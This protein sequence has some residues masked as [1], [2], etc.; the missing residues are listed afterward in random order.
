MALMLQRECSKVGFDLK[1]TK[2][3]NDGYWGAIWLKKP[4]CVVAWNMRPS[5]TMM[6]ALAYKS[7]AAW[8]ETFWKNERF[9]SL[10]DMAT[11]ETDF[12]KKYEMLG[13]MQ[14]LISDEGGSLTPVTGGYLDAHSSKLKGF[15]QNPL[16]AFGG[17]EWPEYIWM[18]S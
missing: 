1:V 13:E 6:L 5:A 10:L 12:S 3:P 15:G 18:D 8:N 11:A 16:G 4:M 2:V 17:M 14:Q 7:T 9:D